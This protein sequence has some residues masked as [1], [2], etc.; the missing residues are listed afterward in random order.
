MPSL[1]NAHKSVLDNYGKAVVHMRKQVKSQRFGFV[2][3]AGVSKGFGIPTWDKLVEKLAKDPDIRGEEVLKVVPARTGLPYRTEMLFEHYKRKRYNASPVQ[4]HHTRGLDFRIGSDWREIVRKHLYAEAEQDLGAGLNKHPYLNQLLPLIQRSHMTVTYNFDDFLEQALLLR[5]QNAGKATSRGFESV[6]NTWTQFRRSTAVIYH[7]N[8]VVPQ[9]LLET[10][11]D[12]FVFSETS[13]AEQLM[14]IFAGDQAGF[15]NHLS[16]HTCLLVGLSLDDETLRNVLMQAARACPGNYHYYVHYI[17]DGEALDEE[18]RHAVRLTNFKV[19]NLVTLFLDDQGIRALGDLINDETCCCDQF[20]DFARI[21]KINIRFRFYITGPMGAGKST[22]INQF[23]NLVVLD[24][25]LEQRPAV[26]AKLW[27]TLSPEEIAAADKWIAEQFAMKNDV[28]RNERE[29][30]FILDRGPLDPLA[31]TPDA[32]WG[33]KAAR[34][35]EAL[36]PGAAWEV[37]DG[38]VILLEGDADELAL[39]MVM[40]QRREYTAK[41]LSDMGSQLAKAYG[42]GGVTVVDTRGFLPDDVARRMAEIVH[43]GEYHPTCG[44]HGRLELIKKEGANVKQN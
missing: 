14:G 30:I 7:P 16:K 2:F 36:C 27:A 29:G 25:W 22:A 11:S 32:E 23:R 41:Q 9:N 44:L 5:S 4:E 33:A 1:T 39:R 6:T 20:C 42:K 10:P 21:H 8:G 17:G 24:E 37:E 18:K 31:F 3:G 28:L 34:L 43:L 15:L 38:H 12:R 19:Y 26:L 35:L 13:Y 40:T